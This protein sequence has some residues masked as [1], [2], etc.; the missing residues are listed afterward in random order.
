MQVPYQPDE[1][2]LIGADGKQRCSRVHPYHRH[3]DGAHCIEVVLIY[4]ATKL[5]EIGANA[6]HVQ[7]FLALSLLKL[8]SQVARPGADRRPV[9][10]VACRLLTG[11]QIDREA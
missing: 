11:K 8:Y 9:P 7:S 3:L 2:R 10:Y 5:N 6:V 4:L 1:A